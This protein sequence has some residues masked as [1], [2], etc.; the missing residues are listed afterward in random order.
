MP[1]RASPI[2]GRAAVVDIGSN[3]IRLVVYRDRSRAAPVVFNERV[4]CGIGRD[5]AATGKL[6]PEGVATALA[7]LPRFAAIVRAMDIDDTVL[8]ATAASREATDGADF[9]V[10]VEAIFGLRVTQLDGEQEA[11]LAAVGVISGLPSARGIAADLGGG[12]LELACIAD[13]KVG[14]HGSLP[15]GPLRLAA[16]DHQGIPLAGYIDAQ[17]GQ[18]DWIGDAVAD[19]A[20]HAVGGAWRALARLHMVQTK[21]PLRVIHNYQMSGR[22]AAEFCHV[23]SGLSASSLSRISVV[24]KARAPILST[25][26]LVMEHLIMA[27]GAE[28][29][30]FSANGIREGSQYEALDADTQAADPLIVACEQLAARES[31]SLGS[32]TALFN[33]VGRLFEDEDTGLCRLRRAACLLADIGWHEHPDY[34]A[35]QVYFRILRLPLMALSHVEKTMIAL[36]VF[37][38]YSGARRGATLRVANALLGQEETD[39]SR[40]L[41]AALRLAETLTGGN[42]VLLQGTQLRLDAE[43]LTLSLAAGQADLCGDLVRTRFGALAKLFDVTGVIESND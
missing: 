28:T 10:Q 33:W 14:D 5:V 12:S 13:G 1:R 34:R 31:R 9:L 41:G 42:S 16:V 35:E 40:R 27:S 23:V 18:F 26:A 17:L 4:T 29:V 7:N 22:E 19:G 37:R 30:S 15:L 24:P 43:R 2:S 3:S 36:A 25:A 8:V 21:Y 32:G 20:V 6:H 38:R 11:R 39:W